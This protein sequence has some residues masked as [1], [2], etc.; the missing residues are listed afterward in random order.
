MPPSLQASVNIILINLAGPLFMTMLNPE[1]AV[2]VL[3]MIVFMAC[4]VARFSGDSAIFY[5]QLFPGE[6]DIHNILHFVFMTDNA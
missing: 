4:C 3:R 5:I 1:L 6:Y 2:I